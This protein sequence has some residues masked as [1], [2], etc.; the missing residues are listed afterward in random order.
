MGEK[1]AWNYS[2]LL[3]EMKTI[4]CRGIFWVFSRIHLR[5][6]VNLKNVC[7]V[8]SGFDSIFGPNLAAI[9]LLV[10]CRNSY[11]LISDD[12]QINMPYLKLKMMLK[13]IYD[14]SSFE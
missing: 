12:L 10:H 6:G 2:C 1:G 13:I 4:K 8:E 3:V 9:P 14:T 5:N 7:L 11:A